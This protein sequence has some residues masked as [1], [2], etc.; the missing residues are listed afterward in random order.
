MKKN[1]KNIK[2]VTKS[3]KNTPKT[4]KGTSSTNK[5]R[6]VAKTPLKST[7][8]VSLKTSQAK[9]VQNK[10]NRRKVQAITIYYK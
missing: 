2:E 7:G 5:S 6:Q 3:A 10:P 9:R 1:T 4:A 8:K